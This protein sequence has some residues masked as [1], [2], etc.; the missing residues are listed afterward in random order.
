MSTQHTHDESQPLVRAW[1]RDQDEVRAAE[2]ELERRG[3]DA[4]NVRLVSPDSTGPRREIDRRS[5]GWIGKRAAVGALVGMAAG[6]LIGALV[7]AAL[8]G[9]TTEV[10]FF[11][12][13]GLIFGTAPG[14]FYA[15]GTRLP[16]DPEVFDTFAEDGSGRTCIAVGGP[17][18]VRA[19]AA[20][21]LRS[22]DP[23]KVE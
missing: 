9:W 19:E 5:M 7:G 3:I 13:G 8:N 20:D 14:F 21:V 17:D 6:A 10:W 23:I 16:A 15:V 12:L 4:V 11:V 22:L 2:V 1:F 18:D